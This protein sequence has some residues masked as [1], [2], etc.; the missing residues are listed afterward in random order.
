MLLR[1]DD[2]HHQWCIKFPVGR[3]DLQ[4]LKGLVELDAWKRR[5]VV[6]ERVSR[7]IRVVEAEDLTLHLAIAARVQGR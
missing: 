1:S 2:E 4:V 7:R 6:S 3:A 5:L